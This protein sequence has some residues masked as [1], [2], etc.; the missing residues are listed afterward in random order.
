L[1]K[2]KELR[3]SERTIK[4][5]KGLFE[6]FINYY[7]KVEI[8]RIDESMITAFLRYLVMERKVSTSYQNQ[9]INAIKFYFE[10]VLGGQRK[11][12]LVDRPREEK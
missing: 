1:L 2:L 8:T 3:Y 10:R 5:Y 6:E 12:Y 4:T 11:V 7:H 9:S